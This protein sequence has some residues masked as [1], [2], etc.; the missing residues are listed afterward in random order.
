MRTYLALSVFVFGAALSLVYTSLF[1]HRGLAHRALTLNPWL[2]AW[3]AWSGVWVT[4]VDPK[5][6]ICMHRLHHAYSD[7]ARD[8]HSPVQ[9]GVV[10]VFTRQRLAYRRIVRGLVDGDPQLT[11]RVA[12]LHMQV[13]A[14]NRHR[15]L[16]C[17]PYGLHLVLAI[18]CGALA[19][20]WLV[21]VA[22]F[23][24]TMS[25]PVVG[26]AVNAFGHHS[27]ARTFATRDNS[28]NN[29]WL[30]WLALGEGY[31][32][33]HHRYPRSARFSRRWP[34]VDAG[35]ALCQLLERMGLLSIR[36]PL[37]MPAA[38]PPV[39]T[40]GALRPSGAMG[41]SLWLEPR[42]KGPQRGLDPPH[43]QCVP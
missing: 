13:S 43:A 32:N 37:L 15:W 4:G 38:L 39:D 27:G 17:L 5:A 11:L 1:F 41:R 16:W 33:N 42:R 24:G 30:G 35:Y 23:A 14:I 28:R 9:V 10:G 31:Q 21:G 2:K 36:R 19:H 12:D 26:W 20:A 40:T 29:L 6:W 18:A 8:P 7:T 3:I 25:H 34:E 22:C